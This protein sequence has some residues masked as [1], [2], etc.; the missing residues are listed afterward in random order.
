MAEKKSDI[1]MVGKRINIGEEG[2]VELLDV[3][4]SDADIATAARVSTGC[5]HKSEEQDERLIR[6]L[7]RH[8]HTSPFEMAELKFMVKCPM[9]VWRQWIRHRTA[10]VNEYS[11][12]YSC[13]LGYCDKKEKGNLLASTAPT[14]WRKQSEK[15]MQ[16]S[17]WEYI[18]QE[19]GDKLSKREQ[20]FQQMARDVYAERIAAGVARE[21]ARKDL[22]LSTYTQAVWKIDLHNLLHFLKLRMDSHA[23]VEIRTYARAIYILVNPLFPATFRAFDDFVRNSVT[24]SAVEVQNLA[25]LLRAYDI[26]YFSHD[27]VRDNWLDRYGTEVPAS[28]KCS[29]REE[30]IEKLIDMGLADGGADGEREES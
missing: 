23:Q 28:D 10:S 30:F 7:M 11:T 18:D 6:Y 25:L 22:P 4:G 5:P 9:D 14:K 26:R 19:E 15:R 12:R 20:E 29:E 8:G 16:G 2:F 24:L 21:Q 13:A 3:M 27:S 1:S 17:A